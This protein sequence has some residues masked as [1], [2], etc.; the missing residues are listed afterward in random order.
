MDFLRI[1]YRD[2]Y[3]K[4]LGNPFKIEDRQL[5]SDRSRSS[6]GVRSSRWTFW[7]ALGLYFRFLHFLLLRNHV[8]KREPQK[9]S[10][11]PPSGMDP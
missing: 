2:P 1:S 11:L 4:T 7:K 8:E 10:L 3:R 5:Q 9:A 6:E